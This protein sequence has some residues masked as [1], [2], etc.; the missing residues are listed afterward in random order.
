MIIIII[1]IIIVIN[2]IIIMINKVIIIINN[3]KKVFNIDHTNE[4]KI[5]K[6][7]KIC[8]YIYDYNVL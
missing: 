1:I 6:N 7:Y 8:L 2:K 4:N 5:L 3:N